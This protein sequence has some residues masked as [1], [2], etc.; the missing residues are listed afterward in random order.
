LPNIE[1][2]W[3]IRSV[4]RTGCAVAL[5]QVALFGETPV[6]ILKSPDGGAE[7]AFGCAAI[8]A[9]RERDTGSM[10]GRMLILG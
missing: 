4:N 8:S 2:L 7:L 9:A 3:R 10:C 6:I 1:L 5:L